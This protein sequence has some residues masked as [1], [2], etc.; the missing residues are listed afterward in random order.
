M[1]WVSGII[2]S[3]AIGFAFWRDR[4]FQ[5][6][7]GVDAANPDGDEEKKT[8]LAALMQN[9]LVALSN[10]VSMNDAESAGR[11]GNQD[12]GA[13]N[14]AIQNKASVAVMPYDPNSEGLVVV[15][16]DRRKRRPK[17]TVLPDA[18]N[19]QIAEVSLDNKLVARVASD[20]KVVSR[21]L[22]VIP[23]SRA[24]RFGWATQ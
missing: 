16:D 23:R 1:L 11:T 13:Q 17:V 18:Q 20:T 19:P 14:V 3:F 24:A 15:W 7:Q 22:R 21:M 6:D 2:V 9:D 8:E 10:G 5:S 12:T 4:L